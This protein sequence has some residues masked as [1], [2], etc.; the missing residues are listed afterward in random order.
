MCSPKQ[1]STRGSSNTPASIIGLAPPGGLS[2]HGWKQNLTVPAISARRSLSSLAT[3]SR[4][5]V[6]PS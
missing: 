6:W 2:S 4:P 1:A 3:L 5:A